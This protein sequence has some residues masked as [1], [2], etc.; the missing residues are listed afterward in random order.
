[1]FNRLFIRRNLNSFAIVLFLILFVGIQM[2]K[3]GF[4][5]NHDGSL[6]QFGVGFNRKTVIPAWLLAIVLAILSYVIVLYYIVSPKIM[7]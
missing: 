2:I 3:P 6:R 4:L 1:M 5:Y 7:Y